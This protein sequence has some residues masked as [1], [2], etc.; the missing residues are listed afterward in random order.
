MVLS[1]LAGQGWVQNCFRCQKK[2]GKQARFY[3]LVHNVYY[4]IK[5]FHIREEKTQ[6]TDPKNNNYSILTVNNKG[7]IVLFLP[8]T[9]FI[10]TPNTMVSNMNQTCISDKL[11]GWE[12]H[13]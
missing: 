9:I 1:P 13:F 2:Y 4:I 5:G 7:E 12:I 3:K 11:L 8:N 10:C 6:I